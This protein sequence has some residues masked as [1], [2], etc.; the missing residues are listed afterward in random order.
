MLSAL[1]QKT[2]S[3][4]LFKA[5]MRENWGGGGGECKF[6]KKRKKTP[7][8]FKWRKKKKE[9]EREEEG[10]ERGGGGGG[11]K[12]QVQVERSNTLSQ[13]EMHQ[14]IKQNKTIAFS[15]IGMFHGI[16]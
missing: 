10:E 15:F 14:I 13:S 3:T 9:K 5:V 4:E 16:C 8:K 6:Q 7:S 11:R 1:G 2:N 12:W